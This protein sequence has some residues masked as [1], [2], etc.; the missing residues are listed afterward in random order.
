MALARA[1]VKTIRVLSLGE[2]VVPNMMKG[3]V[4]LA[5]LTHSSTQT[6]LGVVGKN[7]NNIAKFKNGELTEAN[8]FE[9]FIA[10]LQKATNTLIGS[11][12]FKSAWNE[13]NPQFSDYQNNLLAAI[14]FNAAPN[15]KLILVSLTNPTDV[16]FLLQQ[17]EKN[18]IPFVTESTDGITTVKSIDCVEVHL[19]FVLKL[20]KDNMVQH[21]QKQYADRQL[22]DVKYIQGAD[23]LGSNI[24][25]T[26]DW[27]KKTC[28]GLET[29]LTQ[30]SQ[31][32]APGLGV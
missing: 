24:M 7:Q 26:L 14:R 18:Q 20:S 16:N 19:S 13:M 22:Y 9:V 10:E 11:D 25:E 28:P 12:Q 8:F 32:N 15:H 5:D 29:F 30:A 1:D 31:V 23:K 27:D 2:I 3:V 17:L 6:I 21:I 4:K